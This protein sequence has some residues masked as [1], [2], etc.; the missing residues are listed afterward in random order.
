MGVLAPIEEHLHLARATAQRSPYRAFID[1][2]DLYQDA[3]IG[4]MEAHERFDESKGFLFS[5][6][7]DRLMR[8]RI[9]DGVRTM[10]HLTRAQ[11][12]TV[13]P[14]ER[15]PASLEHILDLYAQHSPHEGADSPR[16][17]GRTEEGYEA[18]EDELYWAWLRRQADRV[19]GNKGRALRLF[20]FEGLSLKET[21][22]RLGV[23]ESAACYAAQKGARELAQIVHKAEALDNAR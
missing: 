13:A 16:W 12:E 5:T 9:A 22:R 15:Q 7:A 17:T 14:H 11:R 8:G 21:G 6:Y 23:T 19:M 2:D 1:L 10:D 20:H 4:L 3:C 18:V